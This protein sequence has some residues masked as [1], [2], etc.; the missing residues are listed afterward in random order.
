MMKLF[1]IDDTLANKISYYLL[2]CFLAFLPFKMLYS[3]LALIGF[4]LC[5]LINFKI[6]K[7]PLLINKQVLVL[8]SIYLL[9]FIGMLYSPDIKEALNVSGRQLAIL[10]FP[11]LFILSDIDLNKYK[12]GLLKI[13]GLS[14]VVAI[15]YL[16]AVAFYTIGFNHLPVGTLFTQGFMNHHFS[17]PIQLHATYLSMYAT[18]AVII[19]LYFFQQH[20]QLGPRIF[21]SICIIVLLAGIIQLS[22]RSPLIALLFIV[23]IIFPVFSLKGKKKIRF[24]I[25]VTIL[26]AAALFSIYN[27]DSYKTRYVGELKNDLGIDTLN[28]EY[29]EP[30]VIRWSGEMEIIKKS[31]FVGY[32]SGSEKGLLH[33]MFL[34]KQLYIAANRYFNS[35]SQYLSFWINMGIPGLACYLFVLGYGIWLAWKER[36]ILFMGFMTFICMVSFSENILFLNKGI[37]FYSFFIT[38]FFVSRKSSA[39]VNV[40]T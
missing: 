18:F 1:L 8:T 33:K 19:F 30:R 31:P 6:K 15:I 24:F 26:S 13:F 28:V 40:D 23:N 11:V 9:G 27:I 25:G 34:E 12:P 4:G 7:L 3:E 32:G 38:L 2:V 14:C 37:F 36:D 39:F 5:T 17:L 22:S 16:Y 29:T 20:N 21:Y 35:H 10:L